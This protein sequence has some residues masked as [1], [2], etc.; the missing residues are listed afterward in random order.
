MCKQTAD[1]DPYIYIYMYDPRTKRLIILYNITVY[2]FNDIIYH[3]I[4]IMG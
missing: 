1:I 2:P 4:Y 3:I